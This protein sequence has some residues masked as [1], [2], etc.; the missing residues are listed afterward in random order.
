MAA[1]DDYLPRSL[2]RLTKVTQERLHHQVRV[3]YAK[4][5]EYQRRGLV[6]LHVVIRLDRAMPKYRAD[7]VK[8]PHGRITVELLERAVRAAVNTIDAPVANRLGERVRW[9]SELEVEPIGAGGLHPG[10]CAGY[11]AKYA[12]KSTE[13]AGGVLHRVAEHARCAA[14]ARAREELHA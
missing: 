6:H 4:V 1:H 2:A 12:T 13:V 10:H 5:V 7:Q 9:G 3:A 8:P 11:L 14:R